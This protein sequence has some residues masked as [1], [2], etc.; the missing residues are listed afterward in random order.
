MTDD[1]LEKEILERIKKKRDFP[2]TFDQLVSGFD[3]K[4][5]SFDPIT[6]SFPIS[7]YFGLHMGFVSA[8]QKLLDNNK[9]KKEWLREYKTT[10][11]NKKVDFKGLYVFI[12]DDTPFYVGIS[13]GVIGRIFQHL[14]GHTHNTCTLAFNIGLIRYELLSGQRHLGARKDFNFK[15]EVEPIKKFLLNHKIALLHIENDE[16]LYLFEIY[17]SMKFQTILNKFETH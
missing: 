11:G 15:S 10:A 5:S 9:I 16:E 1:Q 4:F 7:D 13:K 3:T 6:N 8:K 12:Y 17:C 14:K 2:K